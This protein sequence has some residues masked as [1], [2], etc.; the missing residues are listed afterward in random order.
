M[1]QLPM[2]D[3]AV[4][5]SGLAGLTAAIIAG[6]AGK[7]VIVFER[8]PAAGGR[9]TTQ[10]VEGFHFNQGPHALYRGGEGIEILRELGIQYGGAKASYE[11]SWVMRGQEK[12]PM[13][14]SP[15]YLQSTALFGEESKAEVLA[16]L[17]EIMGQGS[18]AEL[19]G[20]SLREWLNTRVRYKDVRQYFEGMFRLAT[21][22]NDQ[23]EL[24]TGAAITQMRAARDGV[25]YIDGGWQSLIDCMRDAALAAD[26]R[27]ETRSE[28]KGIRCEEGF[29]AI[30]LS[31]DE[32]FQARTVIVTANP[33]TAA[34]MV[35][36]G[37]VLSL[38]QW[39]EEAIPIYAACLDVALRRL[40]DPAHQFAIGLDRPLYYSVHTRSARLAPE[41]GAVIQL[42][43]YLSSAVEEQAGAVRNEL[44]GVLDWLQPGWRDEVV[45]N[46]F[47]PRMLVSNA[48]VTSAQGGSAGRPGP[49]VPELANLYIAGDWVGPDGMLADASMASAR[50]A[51]NLAIQF[52]RS[53]SGKLAEV[54]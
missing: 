12:F 50:D 43:K 40:P 36:G 2:F 4:I 34:R 18:T 13:P 7:S 47:L 9:A 23:D 10:S 46:R 35:N 38:N 26:A 21:Y 48:V 29:A 22:C 31:N 3:V 1:N 32:Y 14:G 45:T 27:I 37:E 53:S 19:D 8:G 33:A 17:G 51:A 30:R 15:E 6:R 16:V 24:S 39:A 44:E 41:G 52:T 49:E 54:R 25:D 5:G 42:A 11:G 28:V 20:I